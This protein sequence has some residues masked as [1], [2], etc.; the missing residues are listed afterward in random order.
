VPFIVTLVRVRVK[1]RVPYLWPFAQ[2]INEFSPIRVFLHWL[3]KW[4]I[5][6]KCYSLIEPLIPNPN[7][8]PLVRVRVKV[9]VG[10]TY[11]RTFAYVINKFA[12]IWMFLHWLDK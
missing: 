4:T 8:V 11:L 1:D 3:N 2:V 6:S 9:R 10:V 5:L 7:I 12:Y